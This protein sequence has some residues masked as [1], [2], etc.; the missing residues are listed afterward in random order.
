MFFAFLASSFNHLSHRG[1]LCWWILFYGFY[2]FGNVLSTNTTKHTFK[3][4]SRAHNEAEQLLIVEQL[5]VNSQLS[6]RTQNIATFA[7]LASP[8][9]VDEIEGI[10]VDEIETRAQLH[11][12]CDPTSICEDYYVGGF[13]SMD[14]IA[15]AMFC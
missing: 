5:F 15:L 10:T 11:N 14:F 6:Q 3:L 13:Y 1:L 8:F 7:F 4:T 12:S 2:R 9:G